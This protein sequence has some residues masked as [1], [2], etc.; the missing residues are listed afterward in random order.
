MFAFVSDDAYRQFWKQIDQQEKDYRDIT[1]ITGKAREVMTASD[2]I[3]VSSGTATLEAALLAKP[4]VV[5]YKVSP[6]SYF[7]M[8]KLSTVDMYSLANHIRR[9][10]G[11]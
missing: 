6:I 5:T 4:M 2:V 9:K 1:C 3:L 8:K 10:T 11:S 7:I